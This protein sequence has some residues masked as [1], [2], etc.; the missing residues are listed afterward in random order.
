MLVGLTMELKLKLIKNL[1]RWGVTVST[2]VFVMLTGRAQ[3]FVEIASFFEDFNGDNG[4]FNEF[5]SLHG[6]ARHHKQVVKI[7]E[8]RTSQ[9]GSMLI[10][11]FANGASF[12][13]FEMSFRLFMGSGSSSPAD[14]L[15][16]SIGNDLPEQV[17]PD[18]EEGAGEGMRICFDAWDSGLDDLAPQIE[19][20]YAGES[21]ASQSFSGPTD[22]PAADWFKGE[23]G[24]DVMMWHNREWADVKIRVFGGKLSLQFR[25][26][27]IF[28]NKPISSGAFKAPQWLFAASTGGAYQKH[29][30]DDLKITLYESIVPT[31]S[32]FSGSPGGFGI[33]MT[34]SKLN[35]V[36]LDSVKVKF[37]GE[38]VDVHKAK[39]DGITDIKYSTDTPLEAASKY[40]VELFY[41]DE[42][43]NSKNVPFEYTVSNY[44]S[45]GG[46]MRADESL[47]GRRGFLVYSTQISGY[48]TGCLLYTSPSPRDQRGSRMPSSA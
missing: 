40:V 47:K 13:S 4:E 36:D 31:V 10:Q 15:S 32:S 5:I 30:I 48:Q 28:D 6:N 8:S 29:Y 23:D 19:V 3:D 12:S 11:D 2:L 1:I 46:A 24:K 14:G 38:F 41:S 25:G 7:T 26:H 22:V 44:K 9:N 20:F 35:G 42:K 18:A 16:I 43:G 34:D 17:V 33:K 37:D 27:T 45:V 21:Q 39:M